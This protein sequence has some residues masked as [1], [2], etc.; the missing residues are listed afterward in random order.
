[1]PLVPVTINSLL[2]FFI[3][4]VYVCILQ[5]VEPYL[6]KSHKEQLSKVLH[7][8]LCLPH[9]CAHMYPYTCTVIMTNIVNIRGSLISHLFF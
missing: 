9:V 8:E 3:I 5:G 4:V 6:N 1:M 2:N 7:I